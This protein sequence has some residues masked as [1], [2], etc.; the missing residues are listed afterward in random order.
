M[1]KRQQPNP[2][3]NLLTAMNRNAMTLAIF[4]FVSV[5]LIAITHHLTKD[6][7]AKEIEISLLKQLA[8]IAEP[9]SYNNDVYKDCVMVED[10]NQPE[11]LI[12][13]KV[14]RLRQNE[15]NIGLMITATAPNGYSG[16]IDFALAVSAN[17]SILGVNVLKHQ[18]TPGLGDKIERNKSDWIKQF[19]NLH[20]GQLTNADWQVKKD[21]GKFDALTGATVT[22]RAIVSAV[23]RSYDFVLKNQLALYAK[24]S[25]CHAKLIE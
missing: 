5:G 23:K 8:I 21:G 24:P 10:I 11:A 6:K 3:S 20:K 4:A 7:I 17:G 14:Y 19:S 1:M 22:P 9:T 13:Q 16:R 2:K 12:G 18:E 15:S 25:D